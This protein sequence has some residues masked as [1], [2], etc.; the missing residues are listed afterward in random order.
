MPVARLAV[1]TTLEEECGMNVTR[2]SS[3]TAGVAGS[4]LVVGSLA[5][6]PV[7]LSATLDWTQEVPTAMAPAVPSPGMGVGSLLYNPLSGV[8]TVNLSVSNLLGNTV[9]VPPPNGAPAHVHIAPP[10]ANGPIIL[11]LFGTPVGVQAFGYSNTF[12]FAGL[13]GAG[14]AQATVDLLEST[15][16]GLVGDAVGT[17][18]GLYL[19]VHT[20]ARPAGEIRGDLFVS[21]VP[22]PSTYALMG[23]GLLALGGVSWRR[24]RA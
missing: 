6:Q 3:L 20:T 19:N 2:W 10:G 11:P 15:L 21:A 1:S 18:A 7:F 22:E 5:A 13:V 23:T 9:P 8:I 24:R 12:T 4:L 14:V 16:N 17:P